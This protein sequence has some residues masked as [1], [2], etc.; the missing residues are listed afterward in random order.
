MPFNLLAMHM[1]QSFFVYSLI[2]AL[3]SVSCAQTCRSAE[4]A[5]NGKLATLTVDWEARGERA[6]ILMSQIHAQSPCSSKSRVSILDHFW[7]HCALDGL[8]ILQNML[9]LHVLC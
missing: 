2:N 5:M 4:P 6:E 7:P 3:L 1:R 9:V 8:L